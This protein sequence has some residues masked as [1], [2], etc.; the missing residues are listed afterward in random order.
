MNYEIIF[1]V[2]VFSKIRAPWIIVIITFAGKHT[3]RASLH[4]QQQEVL[5]GKFDDHI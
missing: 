1:V 3:S 4:K 5:F 2:K